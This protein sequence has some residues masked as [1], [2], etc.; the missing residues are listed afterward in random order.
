LKTETLLIFALKAIFAHSWITALTRL[1][2]VFRRMVFVLA[3][4]SPIFSG[5]KE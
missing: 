3:K 2:A 4:N 5:S 1:F